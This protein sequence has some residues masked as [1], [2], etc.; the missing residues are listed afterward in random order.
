MNANIVYLEQ[1]IP[2][3]T[4]TQQ[5]NLFM[6]DYPVYQVEANGTLT[7][8]LNSWGKV[9]SI[10][11]DKKERFKIFFTSGRTFVLGSKKI[12]A[13]D[14]DLD[15]MDPV[16]RLRS[17]G[18]VFAP[19]QRAV[20]TQSANKHSRS[21][22]PNIRVLQE[23]PREY[24]VIDCEFG[25]LFQTQRTGDHITMDRAVINGEK[26]GI[27]QLAALGYRGSQP[28]DIYFN[29]YFDDPAFSPERK[30]RGLKETGSTLAAYEQESRPVTVL[31]DFIHQVL[32]RQLPL[33]FWNQGNDLRLL[34]H[35]LAVNLPY[36]AVEER[37]ALTAPLCVFDGSL[38]TNQVI[39]RSNHQK[40]THHFLP[41]NGIAGLLNIFN[42]KQHNAVWDAQTTQCVINELAKIKQTKP[43]VI[44]EPRP[45]VTPILQLPK[46]ASATPIVPVKSI[47]PIEPTEPQLPAVA[48]L[49]R[50][51]AAGRTYREIANQFGLSTSTVWRA[52]KRREGVSY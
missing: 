20:A 21:V 37:L 11:V 17:H 42:P 38:Y 12:M 28:L 29:R 24:V 44:Q 15:G 51:R 50:L 23:I 5:H 16:S 2:E 27:F 52:V 1:N 30:L 40:D 39:N 34:Q 46:V 43:L 36:L 4:T 6:L 31:K 3:N 25:V 18:Y 13:Y 48:T 45:V 41:L 10:M 9:L 47:E 26:A 32:R 49:Q 14:T 33:V 22:F 19:E 7:P 8:V 35:T